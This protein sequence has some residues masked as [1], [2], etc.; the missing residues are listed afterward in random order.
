MPRKIDAIRLGPISVSRRYDRQRGEYVTCVHIGRVTIHTS[1][2]V[3]AHTEVW[4]ANAAY[5]SERT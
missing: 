2:L 4:A 5:S 3:A 1:E